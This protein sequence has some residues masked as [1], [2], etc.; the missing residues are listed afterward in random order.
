MHKFKKG[1]KVIC[2][3]HTGRKS[4]MHLKTYTVERVVDDKFISLKEV[5]K[6]TGNLYS[7]IRFIPWCPAFESLFL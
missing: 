5:D 6:S 2:F 3:D 4:L 7:A 1:D